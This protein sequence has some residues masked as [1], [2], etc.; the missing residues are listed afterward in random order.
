[1]R[2]SICWPDGKTDLCYSPSLVIKDYL[3][4][5]QSYS[6]QD[7]LNRTSTALLIASDRVKEKYGRSCSLALSQLAQIEAACKS[8]RD[9]PDASVR[10]NQFI[11]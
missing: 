8:Y 5:G 7:F 1:M 6:L 2:F 10:V 3:S 4:E 9:T 11:E